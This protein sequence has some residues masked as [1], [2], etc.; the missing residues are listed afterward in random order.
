[1]QEDRRRNKES[2]GNKK[3]KKTKEMIRRKED[4]QK[5]N[6]RRRKSIREPQTIKCLE[7][8]NSSL[9]CLCVRERKRPVCK[10]T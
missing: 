6:Y 2:R 1:M 4:E 10:Y 3:A 9:Q 7:D 5:E 8:N